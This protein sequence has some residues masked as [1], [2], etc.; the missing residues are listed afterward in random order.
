MTAN[1]KAF[2]HGTLGENGDTFFV[3]T[4]QNFVLIDTD[5]LIE[6]ELLGKTVSAIGTMGIPPQ[7]L[8]SSS[9]IGSF[10]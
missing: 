1:T 6:D 5:F 10:L 9:P 3:I 8:Q 7:G 2:A 4:L